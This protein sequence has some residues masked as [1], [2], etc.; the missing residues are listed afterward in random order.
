MLGQAMQI[1]AVDLAFV[2]SP[3]ATFLRKANF[4]VNFINVQ[5]QYSETSNI[6]IILKKYK[7]W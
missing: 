7:L 1:E 5:R 6:Q 3:I 2:I 4:T